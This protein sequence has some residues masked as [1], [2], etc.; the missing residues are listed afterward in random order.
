[1]WTALRLDGLFKRLLLIKWSLLA[2][3]S[4][5]SATGSGGTSSCTTRVRPLARPRR[6]RRGTTPL[7]AVR[8]PYLLVCSLI[9]FHYIGCVAGS[10]KKA[11][12]FYVLASRRGKLQLD[13]TLCS[14]SNSKFQDNF[15]SPFCL[16][17]YTYMM[18]VL[19]VLI[20]TLTRFLS[21]SPSLIVS[22][23]SSYLAI[24]LW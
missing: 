15:M 13:G 24:T 1:M 8:L 22:I 14:R 20:N 16:R 3:E 11:S 6:R 21:V 4:A 5:C 17:F 19:C 23:W 7:P 12:S 18:D 10:S 2:S 9:L